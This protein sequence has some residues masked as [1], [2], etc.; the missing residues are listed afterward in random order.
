MKTVQDVA[1]LIL[2]YRGKIVGEMIGYDSGCFRDAF[3]ISVEDAAEGRGPESEQPVSLQKYKAYQRH[4][5]DAYVCKRVSEAR[6]HDYHYGQYRHGEWVCH[7]NCPCRQR[8]SYLDVDEQGRI[9]WKM[10]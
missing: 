5:R 9:V 4:L 3:G 8:G 2:S 7:S 6:P 1:K 10:A